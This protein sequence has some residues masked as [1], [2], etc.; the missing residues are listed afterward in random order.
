M[1]D[2]L[3]CFFNELIFI[4][5]VKIFNNLWI[6]VKLSICR[7][8]KGLRSVELFEYSISCNLY[9]D[10]FDVKLKY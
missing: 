6:K 9:F 7:F 3:I 8:V 5:I 2:I 1:L 10:M 4:I